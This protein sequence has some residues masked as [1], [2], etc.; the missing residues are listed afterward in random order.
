MPEK[1][2]HW[3]N[4][5]SSG[6]EVN[7]VRGDTFD[8]VFLPHTLQTARVNLVQVLDDPD[9][10]RMSAEWAP[11]HD[12]YT[13]NFRNGDIRCTGVM[14]PMQPNGYGT[15]GL[16]HPECDREFDFFEAVM[17]DDR[18]VY[19]P[20][21]DQYYKQTVFNLD[22]GRQYFEDRSLLVSDDEIS[23]TYDGYVARVQSFSD[24]K[25]SPTTS[26]LAIEFFNP[27][28]RA[29][30]KK[31]SREKMPSHEN[32]FFRLFLCHQSYPDAPLVRFNSRAYGHETAILDH[33]KQFLNEGFYIRVDAET[34]D[35][36][37]SIA[38][39]SL[40][41]GSVLTDIGER[42]GYPELNSRLSRT[43]FHDDE[44]DRSG[45]Y[46]EY[47]GFVRRGV[48]FLNDNS[49]WS[50][51]ISPQ[52]YLASQEPRDEKNIIAAKLL[53]PKEGVFLVKSLTNELH[54]DV[55]R[56]MEID[57]EDRSHL[58]VDCVR[59]DGQFYRDF[60]YVDLRFQ[61]RKH[62]HLS[63]VSPEDISRECAWGVPIT[64]AEIPQGATVHTLQSGIDY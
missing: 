47:G 11:A 31:Y 46:D 35:R 49:G 6:R 64:A 25:G 19:S 9:N 22:K 61:N 14:A 33:M 21:N 5:V 39:V 42:L 4:V 30:E 60:C 54:A 3:L 38:P 26:S 15:W 12:A 17:R 55:I 62:P 29:I 53:G 44:T 50:E 59:P 24:T 28:T 51:V 10:S 56:I 36:L 32:M 63:V 48:D 45:F 40:V 7:R 16:G 57:R 37:L 27:K 2:N 43:T 34:M 13:H 1:Q 41:D 8:H 23:N 52:E 18:I 58:G 20:G